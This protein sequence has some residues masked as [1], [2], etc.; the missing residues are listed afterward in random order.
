MHG[1]GDCDLISTY[2]VIWEGDSN[3]SVEFW[4]EGLGHTVDTN[5]LDHFFR[6]FVCSCGTCVVFRPAQGSLHNYF[7]IC[8][9]L[10][11]AFLVSSIYPIYQSSCL[12]IYAPCPYLH[13]SMYLPTY[14]PMD[15]D[16][17]IPDFSNAPSFLFLSLTLSWLACSLAQHTIIVAL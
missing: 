8:R 5:Q 3:T 13:A 15:K 1:L 6:P 11:Q 12:S 14:L 16:C 2:V 7:M 10:R 9:R 17:N 4:Q